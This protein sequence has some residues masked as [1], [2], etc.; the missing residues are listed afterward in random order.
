[1]GFNIGEEV[2]GMCYFALHR[3]EG[4]GGRKFRKIA[5]RYRYMDVP[6]NHGY[7]I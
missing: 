2:F 5:L 1:M 6:L 4:A 7:F 3:G